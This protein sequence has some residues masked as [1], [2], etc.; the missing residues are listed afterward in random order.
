MMAKSLLAALN[1]GSSAIAHEGSL[2]LSLSEPATVLLEWKRSTAGVI[3]YR[4][5]LFL[6]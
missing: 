6:L 3:A 2:T 4:C 1:S 5:V